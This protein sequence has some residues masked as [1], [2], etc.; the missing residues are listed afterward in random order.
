MLAP[1]SRRTAV[2]TS[3]LVGLALLTGCLDA[4]ESADAGATVDAA[5]PADATVEVDLMVVDAAIDAAVD[6]AAP[7]V[8]MPDATVDAATDA[9]VDAEVVDA[10]PVPADLGDP[11]PA[12]DPPLNIDP[13]A[14]WSRP[15]GLVSLRGTG[16]SGDYLFE[17]AEDASGGLLNARTGAFLV[18]ERIGAVDRVRLTDS[19]CIGEAWADVEAVDALA[20]L[21]ARAEVPLGATFTFETVGGSGTVVYSLPEG[22]SGG[23]INGAGHYV[24][25][26]AAG[27][28]RVR[29]ADAHTGETVD[30]FIEVRAGV[31]LQADPPRLGLPLGV[32][33]PLSVLGGSGVF[34]LTLDV[35]EADSAITLLPD[36]RVRAE[37]PGH[38]RVTL[39]DHFLGLSTTVDVSAVA[40]VSP[41]L[42]RVGQGKGASVVLVPG[43]LDGD[44]HDEVLVG[45]PDAD[46]TAVDGGAVFLYRGGPDGPLPEP[47]QII[48]GRGRR[49]ELGR[50]LAVADFD[51]DGRLDLAVTAYLA[52]E[53]TGDT[54]AVYLHRGLADGTFSPDPYVTLSGINGSDQA[55][56]SVVACDFNGDGRNDLALGAWLHEDRTLGAAGTNQGGVLIWLGYDD[57]FLPAPDQILY[58]VQPD[59]AGGFEPSND[60]RFGRS[61]AAGDFNHDGRCDVAVYAD[62]YELE[63]A[64]TN[65]DGMVQVYVGVPPDDLGSGGL[66]VLP[67]FTV[68]GSESSS[69]SR[70]GRRMAAGDLNGDGTDDLVIGSYL[71][72]ASGNDRGAVGVYF[73]VPGSTAEQVVVNFDQA[74]L[75]LQGDNGGDQFGFWV[76]VAEADDVPG[77]DLLVGGL[78][79]EDEPANSSRGAVR[80]FTGPLLAGDPP[81]SSAVVGGS[82]NGDQFGLSVGAWRSTSGLRG[83]VVVDDRNDIDGPDVGALWFAPAGGPLQQLVVP[84]PPGSGAQLGIGV[85]L[86]GDLDGT[87]PTVAVGAP[88]HATPSTGVRGGSAWL[89]DAAETSV[90][91]ATFEDGPDHSNSDYLGYNVAGVGDFDGDGYDD[92][93]VVRRLDER[94][95]N[96]PAATWAVEDPCGPRRGDAGAVFIHRGGPGIFDGQ[97]DFAL[98]GSV[99]SAGLHSIGF[100]DVDGDGRTDVL[101]GSR[102]WDVEGASDAGGMGLF[103][104][105]APDP[106]GKVVTVCQ[107]D[108]IWEGY[109]AGAQFGRALSGMGDL[110]GD[111]CEE[112]AIGAPLEDFPGRSNIGSVRVVYGWGGPGCPAEPRASLILGPRN[113]AQFGFALASADLDGDGLRELVAGAPANQVNGVTRGGVLVVSGAWLLARDRFAPDAD[114]LDGPLVGEAAALVVTL[115]GQ[116]DSERFGASVDAR[117]GLVAAGAPDAVVLGVPAVGAAR[118]WQFG[119]G[120]SSRPWATFV[121]EALRPGGLLGDAVALGPV[122]PGVLGLAVGGYEGSGVALDAGA[123]YVFAVQEP[124]SP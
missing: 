12:C 77:L 121:G 10:E 85:A 53:G 76:T 2:P 122:A 79:D 41:P 40:P 31:T 111:G 19:A 45:W 91:R 48:G 80:L 35:P 16:G 64:R 62:Q 78:F 43:D 109:Q 87:G 39:T 20:A 67:T 38:H 58:G 51:G 34:D 118:V 83:V 54:G 29:V 11:R 21:P 108:W 50:A 115:D 42:R 104:G 90:V 110:D 120:L 89:M 72:D 4:Q 47:A 100:A 98:Y 74:P 13:P 94:L 23:S 113:S 44:G 97:P 75:M 119:P 93:A 116:T 70:T 36:M 63:P 103:R 6:A 60:L 15:F 46:V 82:A 17:L 27:R 96:P 30:V 52:D 28:D 8:A 5:T 99:T 81:A 49:D 57:G 68:T 18:G 112:F 71:F 22:R 9:A 124:P 66:S 105:R 102:F 92:L 69:N 25:G 107:P 84:G 88:Q 24:A 26:P 33:A 123:V 101:A 65:Y 14:A 114:P 86:P 95:S 61:M 106:D 73:E 32:T 117:D 56:L 55:G 37:R 3:L 59:G 1:P 7:D